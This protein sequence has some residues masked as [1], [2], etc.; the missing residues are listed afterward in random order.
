VSTHRYHRSFFWGIVLHGDKIWLSEFLGIQLV[1]ALCILL[2]AISVIIVRNYLVIAR[3]ST[4][5]SAEHE[6][7]V[8]TA[9][10][11]SGL[12]DRDR[13]LKSLRRI[14]GG[15]IADERM[16]S[17]ANL[18]AD[19]SRKFG[20]DP[21]LVLAVIHVESVFQSDALGQ[22][23][24]GAL[25]GAVGLMQIKFETAQAVAQSLGMHVANKN[26]LLRPEINIP[27]GIAYLAQQIALFHSFKLGLLAYNLGP[28]VVL[29]NLAA[30]KPLPIE[31]YNRILRSYF[32]LRQCAEEA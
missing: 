4:E 23:E 8:T 27:L 10:V 31:Y 14:S 25:S 15:A 22:Y 20:Y 21:L 1:A 30:K 6:L 13:L 16:C 29:Q 26:D 19:N 18:V 28:A 24:S 3:N 17:L 2:T 12:R 32:L 7:S 11:L 9:Y 5:I